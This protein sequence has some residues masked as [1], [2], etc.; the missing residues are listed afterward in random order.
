M[1]H[2]VFALCAG[3]LLLGLMPG[4]TLASASN[5]DQSNA[6]VPGYTLGS[7]N[8]LAQTFTAGKSGRLSAVDLWFDNSGT[9]PVAIKATASGLPVGADLATASGTASNP[10]GWVHFSFPAPPMVTAGTVYAIVFNTGATAAVYGSPNNYAGGQALLYNSGW[11]PI[12]SPD[13]PDWAFQTYVDTV[14][15]VSQWDKASIAAGATTPLT[16]TVTMTFHNGA[17]AKTYGVLAGGWPSWYTPQGS[18]CSSLQGADPAP[19]CTLADLQINALYVNAPATGDTLT[20]IVTGMAAPTQY[21]VGYPGVASAHAWM[22][23]TPDTVFLDAVG[24]ATVQVVAPDAATPTPPPAA[25]PTPTPSQSLRAAT[26]P[27]TS[28]GVGSGSDGTGSTIWLLPIGLLAF[29]GGA[30]ALVIRRRR[31][32]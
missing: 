31:L 27:P 7:T 32:A 30:F 17:E 10:A 4:S 25:T 28:A 13:R 18:T 16:L 26:L 21:D 12:T 19:V 15:T 8:D 9:I 24:A 29:L 14:T 3:L 23:Y 20:V 2:R 6:V 5:L 22:H 1:K 11:A